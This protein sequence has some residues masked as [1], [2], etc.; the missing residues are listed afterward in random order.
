[1]KRI[2][3]AI[4]YRDGTTVERIFSDRTLVHEWFKQYSN[5]DKDV[6]MTQELD[7]DV[8]A[9][10][11]DDVELLHGLGVAPGVD[12]PKPEEAEQAPKQ[13]QQQPRPESQPKTISEQCAEIAAMF[14]TLKPGQRFAYRIV[15]PPNDPAVSAQ[16]PAPSSTQ[17]AKK[18]TRRRKRRQ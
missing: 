18:R 12:E 1:M 4:I 8:L 6:T 11:D 5:P 2:R 9:L 16:P 15:P 10:T 14:G 13:Q 3:A 7:E 17:P